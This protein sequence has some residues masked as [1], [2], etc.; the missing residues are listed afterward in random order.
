MS[1]LNILDETTLPEL[2]TPAYKQAERLLLLAHL[3]VNWDVW[4]KR[5]TKYWDALTDRAR[6][7][8]YYGNSLL[9]WWTFISHDLDTKPKTNEA[10]FELLENLSTTTHAEERQVLEALRYK[11]AVLVL[12]I[13]VALEQSK[14]KQQGE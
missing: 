5:H 10:R 1:K 8:T 3:G 2:P 7:G 14:E 4:G 6:A 13:R 9:D 12:R 11:S